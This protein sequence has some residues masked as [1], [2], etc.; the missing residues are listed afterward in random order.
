MR[1]WRIGFGSERRTVSKSGRY[2]VGPKL[3]LVVSM[4]ASLL[5]IDVAGAPP[6]HAATVRLWMKYAPVVYFHH[7]ETYF[8]TSVDHFFAYSDLKFS[9]NNRSDPTIDGFPRAGRLGGGPN[10]YRYEH[11]GRTYKSTQCTRPRGDACTS[12]PSGLEDNEG[13]YLDLDEDGAARNEYSN[14]LTGEFRL[15]SVVGPQFVPVYF[16]M[17]ALEAGGYALTYWFFYPYNEKSVLNH[18]GDWEHISIKLDAEYRPLSV[19]H[20]QHDAC[21]GPVEWSEA[22]RMFGTHP[23]VYSAQGG[24]AS[25]PRNGTGNHDICTTNLAQ[26]YTS[27]SGAYWY[28]WRSGLNVRKQ[29]WY[30]YGGGWGEVGT[31][32]HTTGPLGP[33][34]FKDP[35]PWKEVA[36]PLRGAEPDPETLVPSDPGPDSD[37]DGVAD[38]YDNCPN[39]AGTGE[40]GCAPR[41]TSAPTLNKPVA[42]LSNPYSRTASYSIEATDDVGVTQMRVKAT[43]DADWRPWVDYAPSGTVIL[44]DRYGEFTIYFQVRDAAGNASSQR[45]ADNV[46][47]LQD[48]TAPTLGKPIATRSDGN[49]AYLSFALDAADN[50]GSVSQMR[51]RLGPVE[52]EWRAWQDFVANGTVVLPGYGDYM[53]W[54]EV[55]DPYGNV[56]SARATDVIKR[57]AAV[58]LNLQQV[59]NNGNVRSCGSTETTPCSDIVKKFRTTITSDVLPKMDLLVKLWRYVNGTWTETN[60]SPFARYAITSSTVN[61][62]FPSGAIAGLWR[63]QVQVQRDDY[64]YTDFAASN[65]QYIQKS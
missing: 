59:D 27:D 58:N 49:S 26:D 23:I 12:R 1:A 46:T 34:P 21:G 48:T 37:G 24:H 56:S 18:E 31:N 60:P 2:P 19:R 65:Y 47:R 62:E 39:E 43:G 10:Y 22:N 54:F 20:F 51:V 7:D 28:T 25:Y 32:T 15:P 35:S 44:P 11:R 17:D 63:V 55:M 45:A 9:R 16:Q 33:S 4:L 5:A 53:I 29:P 61:F 42:S 50:S 38:E 52:S 41:D 13:F 14:G 30:G 40:D 57:T 64:N 8:P 3:L 36:S 6:A